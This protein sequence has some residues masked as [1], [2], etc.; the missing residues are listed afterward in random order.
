MA[1]LLSAQLSNQ[2]ELI[3]LEY[4]I[5]S[6]F[7]EKLNR[8][9]QK[10]INKTI[11]RVRSF[12][13][14]V[15]R[16][17][18]TAVEIVSGNILRG[19]FGIP[20]G[21]EKERIEAIINTISNN[22]E[23]VFNKFN[24]VGENLEGT[25]RIQLD[26]SVYDE[27]FNLA[28]GKVITEKGETLPW[29]KWLMTEG[30]NVIFDLGYSVL[31]KPGFGRSQE[32]IMVESGGVFIVNPRFAGTANDNWITRALYDPQYIRDVQKEIANV[33]L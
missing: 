5:R 27:I 26:K 17:E 1:V 10:K 32:A 3:S 7:V 8:N 21:S 4:K 28:E 22:I 12:T 19:E 24:N 9:I 23:V 31:F 15:L 33:I 25:F 29:L 20:V 14:K 6:V 13:R 2:H 30:N 18:Q 11:T 16:Q